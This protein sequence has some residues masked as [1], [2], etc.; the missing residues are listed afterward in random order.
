MCGRKR[1]LAGLSQE[2]AANLGTDQVWAN[3]WL[4]AL[5]SIWELMDGDEDVKAQRVVDKC[6]CDVICG[7]DGRPFTVGM[8][9]YFRS[10]HGSLTKGIKSGVIKQLFQEGGE[11]TPVQATVAY[12]YGSHSAQQGRLTVDVK[13]FYATADAVPPENEG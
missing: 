1:F 3:A 5:Q 13:H 8:T 4:P 10:S 7:G 12:Q 9:R 11:Q 2:D 6:L